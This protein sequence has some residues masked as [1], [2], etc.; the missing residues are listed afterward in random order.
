MVP[1]V[2][3]A[4]ARARR[5]GAV[6]VSIAGMVTRVGLVANLMELS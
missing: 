4:K 6:E 5:G 2:E 3:A 1:V